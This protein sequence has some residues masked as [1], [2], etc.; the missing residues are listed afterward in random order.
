MGNETEAKIIAWRT[1][2]YVAGLCLLLGFGIGLVYMATTGDAHFYKDQHG[3]AVM[4]AL[5]NGYFNPDSA[6]VPALDDFLQQ[7][8]DALDVSALPDDIPARATYEPM[9]R[10]YMYGQY[11]VAG[12]WV[13]FGISWTS[14]I[15]LFGAL[16]GVS[17]ALS[18]GVF[19]LGMGRILS[20]GMCF[21]F[22]TAPVHL[23]MLPM[24]RDYGKVPFMLGFLL[25]LGVLVKCP[26]KSWAVLATGAVFGALCGLGLGLRD[27]VLMAIPAF[28]LTVLFFLPG[29]LR[30]NILPKAG[31][32][33]LMA[34]CFY[35]CAYPILQV[36][37]EIGAC[38]GDHLYLGL[39]DRCSD[40]LGVGGA[41]YSYGGPYSDNYVKGV[42]HSYGHRTLNLEETPDWYTPEYDEVGLALTRELV[43]T[44]PA[45]FVIRAYASVL[46]LLDGMHPSANRPAPDGLA[47][48]YWQHLYGFHL[49]V[50]L[51]LGLYTRYQAIALVAF[52]SGKELRIGLFVL[53]LGLCLLGVN[54][55]QFN[56]RHHFHLLFV[57]L[58]ISGCLVHCGCLA[59][60]RG[61]LRFGTRKSPVEVLH[62][63][64]TWRGPVVRAVCTVLLIV[65]GMPASLWALRIVQHIHLDGVLAQYATADLDALSFEVEEIG[66]GRVRVVP[67]E[68]AQMTDIPA[69]RE[70]WRLHGELL[71]AEFSTG[72][73]D[74]P[75]ALR[76]IP[77]VPGVD[78]PG[79]DFSHE[80]TIPA[81]DPLGG[82]T[83]RSYIP[84]YYADW[85]E[86][87]G[88]EMAREDLGRLDGLYRWRD[89]KKIPRLLLFAHLG[90]DWERVSRYERLLDH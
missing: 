8:V 63:A 52:L 39:L 82:T 68:F 72:G 31:A 80:M 64:G 48:P 59:L 87:R 26:L 45:D 37:K 84:I 65:I 50:M 78:Y 76:F 60:Y 20:V 33:I 5:G 3:P 25:M 67:K 58:W 34:V 83:Q 36:R 44:F 7:R 66:D 32:I 41:P 79:N 53:F 38:E 77:E 62:P 46:R 16:Y 73:S 30:R 4:V 47:F 88:L 55:V 19:R 28:V 15:F 21:L 27:D 90:P 6:H 18:Y 69:G 40:R 85:S 71:V 12:F 70:E 75:V 11:L 24:L 35:G 61:W 56:L 42:I 22:I 81:G 51:L 86:F 2:C 17:A 1:D 14:L 9:Q 23:S 10:L 57:P 29:G 43:T 13:L 54:A 49:T 74:I 89:Y